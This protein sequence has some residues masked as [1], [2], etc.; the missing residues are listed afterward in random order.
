MSERKEN[1][2]NIHPIRKYVH[3][4][5]T[6]IAALLLFFKLNQANL[7]LAP[8]FYFFDYYIEIIKSLIHKAIYLFC[9]EQ[10]FELGY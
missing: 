4:G 9:I 8:L 1:N 5:K 7:S 6:S 3:L 10:L 2:T